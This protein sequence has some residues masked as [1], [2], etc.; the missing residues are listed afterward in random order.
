MRPRVSRVA[1]VLFSLSVAFGMSLVCSRAY[2][3][4]IPAADASLDPETSNLG[5]SRELQLEVFINGA[6]TDLVAAFRQDADGTLAI[7]P[8][9]LRNVGIEPA[10]EAM[11]DDGLI[12]IARMPGVSFEF[13]EANQLIHFTVE[14][15]ALSARV[16]EAHEGPKNDGSAP[17]SESSLGAL[18][19]YTLFGSTGGDDIED[20]W[21][22]EGVS[23]WFEGRAFSPLGVLT[24][25]YIASSSSSETYD[26]TRLDTTWSYSSPET[27]V[28]Y[29]VGDVISGG[30]GWTRPVR[31]AGI[32][33]RRNFGLRPDLVTMPLPELSGSAAVP[34]TVD[35]YV[36]NARRLSQQIPAGPFQINDLPVITGSGTARVVVRD[37]LGRE[38]VSETPFFAS[39]DLLAPGLWDFS[40]EGGF[41]R[42]FYGTESND[43]DGRF[44]ASGTLRYGKS[45]WLTLEGHGEGGGGLVNGGAGAV[46]RLGHYGVGSL[47]GAASSFDG[48]TGFQVAASIELELWDLH[49]FARTQRTFGDYQDIASITFDPEPP[50][51]PDFDFISAAPPRA[52]DQVSVSVPLSFDPATLNFSY[53]R[54][55]TVENERSQILGFSLNRPFGKSTFFAN[56]FTDLDDKDSFGVFVG[57]SVPFGNDIYA[58]TGVSTD[59]EGTSVTTDLVK[60]ESAEI[61]SVGWR[62]R[63]TEGAYVNRAAS[64]SYRAPMARFE[65]GVQQYDNLFRAT[66]QADGALVLAGGDVFLSNRIDDAF[67]VVDTGEPGIDVQFENRPAGRTNRRGKLLVPDLRSYEPNQITIDPT[68]LPVD[69]N[70][71]GTRE[72]SVPADRSGTV[73]KFAVETDVQAALVTLRDENGEFLETGASGEIEGGSERFTV[74]YD[75]QAYITG[76]GSRNRVVIDQPTRGRCAAEFSFQPQKGEQ[77]TIPDAIC[78]PVQ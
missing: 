78:R 9:Q 15:D 49:F 29:R 50:L 40:A 26:S 70:V 42:R 10:D 4:D 13:D 56:A 30:L 76:L 39:S 61:G 24:T 54:L 48:Q 52:L 16:I 41:A 68:N 22:F 67:A 66:A 60:S 21:E 12:D 11:R 23:G 31:L 38:T 57:L 5:V 8:D 62:I 14:Y 64:V 6:S 75:G 20:I 47:S 35:V 7:D 69:A 77:V 17:K 72:V 71:G 18:V 73:V 2:A 46:F 44:M 74:G 28:S 25:S 51:T 27:M 58:S 36:N 34:S 63:D 1:S 32:Q 65:A 55:E 59:S 43:Y 19:N 45:D 37:A 53:T 3:E 33:I